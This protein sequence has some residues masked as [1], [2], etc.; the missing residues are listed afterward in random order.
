MAWLEAK[1][2]SW[3]EK[4]PFRDKRSSLFCRNVNSDNGKKAAGF[5]TCMETIPTTSSSRVATRS[6]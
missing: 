2:E 3:A 4:M 6:K 1:L 5:D